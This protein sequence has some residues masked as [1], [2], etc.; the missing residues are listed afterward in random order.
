MGKPSA[1]TVEVL[2]NI[3]TEIGAG[4]VLGPR[5]P[6]EVAH[7]NACERALA[8]VAM[9]RRGEGLFQIVADIKARRV[10]K[11]GE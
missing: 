5:V 4:R 9:Y 2:R 10:P 1:E 6:E 8:I 7:N 11:A 3:E